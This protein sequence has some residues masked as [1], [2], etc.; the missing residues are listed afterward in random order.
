[1]EELFLVQHKLLGYIFLHTVAQYRT[2]TQMKVLLSEIPDRIKAKLL[3]LRDT[4]RGWTVLHRA[5]VNEKDERVI[6]SILKDVKQSYESKGKCY[7]N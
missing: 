3:M 7:H 2:A 4:E 5:A 1:M 6:L